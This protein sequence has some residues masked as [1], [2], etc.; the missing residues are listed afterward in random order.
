MPSL[1]CRL[2]SGSGLGS[3]LSEQP[4]GKKGQGDETQDYTGKAK[5]GEVRAVEYRLAIGEKV[6]S[7]DDR[8]CC[9]TLD[10]CRSPHRRSRADATVR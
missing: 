5:G 1:F 8:R 7:A 6:V 9:P 3:P 10:R 4:L 2:A